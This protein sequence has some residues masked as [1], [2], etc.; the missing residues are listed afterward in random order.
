MLPLAVFQLVL[1][2]VY[3][4]YFFDPTALDDSAYGGTSWDAFGIPFLIPA[5]TTIIWLGIFFLMLNDEDKSGNTERM[6][7]VYTDKPAGTYV[8]GQE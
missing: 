1:S 4:L 7:H 3:R 6:F 5:I 2:A 8:P